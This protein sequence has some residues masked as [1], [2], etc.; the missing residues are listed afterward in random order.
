MAIFGKKLEP[1]IAARIPPGQSL[2][3]RFPVLHYGPVPRIDLEK[4]D[5]KLFGLVNEQVS[6]TWEE[7]MQLPQSQVTMDIHCVT[8]WSKLDTSWEGVLATDLMKHVEL[9][10]QA[11][12]VIAHAEYGFTANVP[13]EVFLDEQTIFAHSFG[14][15]PLEKDHGWPL[16]LVVP[17]KYFWK[18]AKWIRGIEF[19]AQDKLGF[20][21]RNG[22]NNHADPWKEER[23]SE[24]NW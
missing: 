14:G 7:F 1:E 15:K 19:L 9:K 10:P 23:Y 22:Y 2:T 17:K 16:R 24:D 6:F 18:S 11:K 5:F 4:W 21:E 12:F 8:R 13:L 3:D 20:W